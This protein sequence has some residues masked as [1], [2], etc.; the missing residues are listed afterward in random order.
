[1]HLKTSPSA[2]FGAGKLQ[3]GKNGTHTCCEK[4]TIK[5]PQIQPHAS[6]VRPPLE[7]R[8]NR[9]FAS[10]VPLVSPLSKPPRVIRDPAVIPLALALLPP[11]EAVRRAAVHDARDGHVL[12]DRL[13]ERP[14]PPALL[15]RDP[16]GRP[17][18]PVV[19]RHLD[20]ADLHV[21]V[22]DRVP[23]DAERVRARA[24]VVGGDAEARD[25]ADD[26]VDGEGG[27]G[28]RLGPGEL[29]FLARVDLDRTHI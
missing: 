10:W 11:P 25:G 26:G 4:A 1:M 15:V 23:F 27:E 19:D 5:T 8:P 28:G 21:P 7:A 24:G 12:Q 22:R 29:R 20:G 3:L 14:A 13:P 2:T 18:R 16:R 9:R 17:R 6:T